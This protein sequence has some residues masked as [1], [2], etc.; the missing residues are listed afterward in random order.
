MYARVN[1]STVVETAAAPHDLVR[2]SDGGKV[3]LSQYITAAELAACGWFV[4]VEP[5]PP[6]LTALQTRDPDTI[7]VVG[8]VPTR[9][10][11]VR[12]KTQ[13]EL[14][15]DAAAAQAITERQQ[16]R[17]AIADLDAFLALQSPTNAQVVTVVRLL[18]R[19]AK[20]LIRDAI[21]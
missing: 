14:D 4:V 13:A 12:N 2:L 1:G 18:C 6:T 3:L 9:V 21:A 17:D 19:V 10:Y 5:A 20:R 8:G 15:A 7:E 11:H 16:A